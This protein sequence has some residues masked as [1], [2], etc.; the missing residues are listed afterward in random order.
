MKKGI[1]PNY[2]LIN[3][4]RTD[5]SSFITRSTWGKEGDTLRL[6]IDPLTH[7]AWTK[8]QHLVEKGQL[9]K[10]KQ[11]FKGFGDLGKT[12]KN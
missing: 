12:P 9:A 2:H 8:K 10:F 5:G 11:R 6:E 1:H 7:V 4:V 3:V